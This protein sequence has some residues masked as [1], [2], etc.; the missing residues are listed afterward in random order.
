MSTTFTNI[1]TKKTKKSLTNIFRFFFWAISDKARDVESKKRKCLDITP[2]Q[3]VLAIT[4]PSFFV[5]WE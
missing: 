3:Y 5:V 4:S 2:H 1:F